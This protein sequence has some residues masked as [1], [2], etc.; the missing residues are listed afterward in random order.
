[1]LQEVQ[2]AVRLTAANAPAV[3]EGVQLE[4]ALR[5]VASCEEP[6]AARRAGAPCSRLARLGQ[7]GFG[8]ADRSH[9]Q[10]A[11]GQPIG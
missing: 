3:R 9:L 5:R 4:P 8:V 6:L 1:M 7:Q 2:P 10:H 11:G